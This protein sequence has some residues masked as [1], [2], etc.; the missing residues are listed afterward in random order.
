MDGMD[1]LAADALWTPNAYKNSSGW[2]HVALVK[3][4]LTGNQ[5]VWINGV[6]TADMQMPGNSTNR[7]IAPHGGLLWIDARN[8]VAFSALFDELAIY[9]TAVPG[10]L[11]YQHYNDS[12]TKHTPYTPQAPSSP[13][14]SPYVKRSFHPPCFLPTGNMCW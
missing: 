8:G 4:G 9:N 6:C 1:V 13:A 14:P 3:D 5:S 7:M 11:L 2:H 12:V 10:A